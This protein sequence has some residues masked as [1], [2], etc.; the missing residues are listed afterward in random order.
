MA[1][2]KVIG[3]GHAGRNTV[4]YLENNKVDG[5][6]FACL[7]DM[8]QVASAREYMG[9]GTAGVIL[10]AGLDGT[11]GSQGTPAIAKLCQDGGVPFAAIVFMPF[12]YE[13]ARQEAALLSPQALRQHTNHI[14]VLSNDKLREQFGSLPVEE[15]FRKGDEV[16]AEVV[17][18]IVRNGYDAIV[19]YI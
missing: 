13:K 11:T 8:A 3:V 17:G 5:V 7:T 12:A 15:A 9:D 10:V 1:N 16:V 14:V 4:D 19:D 6:E 2:I 18:N